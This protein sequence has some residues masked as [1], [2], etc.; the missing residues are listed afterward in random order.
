MHITVAVN[1]QSM[2][3]CHLFCSALT[4]VVSMRETDVHKYRNRY[5]R[6][7]HRKTFRPAVS[8]PQL[9]GEP[10]ISE[11]VHR[12]NNNLFSHD[13]T[14]ILVISAQDL[15]DSDD[16]DSSPYSFDS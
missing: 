10:P 1:L 13:F 2:T 4:R 15:S 11:E 3:L 9:G 8:A 14:T 16:D 5:Q 7:A 12:V 6:R